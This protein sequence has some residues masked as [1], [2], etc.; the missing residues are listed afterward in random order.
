[1]VEK[2]E[3]N[4]EMEDTAVDE[5]EY[6]TKAPSPDWQERRQENSRIKEGLRKHYHT[7]AER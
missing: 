1:M 4:R 6:G 7:V 2:I 5:Q 3:Q